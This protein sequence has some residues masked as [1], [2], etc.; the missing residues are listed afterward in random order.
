MFN[1][2]QD[3]GR[4]L[5]QRLRDLHPPD[6]VVLALPRGGVVVGAE[7][8]A[9]LECPLDVLVVRKL[10]APHQPEL[11]IGAVTDDGSP[12][13]ILNEDLIRRLGVDDRYVERE[14]A[15]QLEEVR[16]RQ[17]LYRRGQAAVP[18]AGRTVIVVDDGIA[19]GATVRAGLIGLRQ[20]ASSRVVLAVPVAP[21]EAT[22]RLGGEVDDL[23]CLETPA[24]FM[25]VGAFYLDFRQV[26]DEEVVALLEEATRRARRAG[27][28]AT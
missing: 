26:T 10:G 7:V 18:I 13:R 12:Q 23:I 19:T 11:A 2:R 9:G 15:G 17:A 5:A 4:Q 6:P 14:I 1:D 3:A 28:E 22:Q 27:N 24:S 25:A 16:R 21:P 20:T 8:A